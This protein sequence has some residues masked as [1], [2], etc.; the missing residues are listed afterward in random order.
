MKKIK[1]WT[2]YAAV[3]TV[4]GLILTPIAPMVIIMYYLAD[5]YRSPSVGDTTKWKV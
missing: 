3:L 1:E 4:L 5:K 2:Q